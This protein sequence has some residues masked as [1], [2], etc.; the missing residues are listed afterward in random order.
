MHDRSPYWRTALRALWS[1]LRLPIV[2]MLV[3][4]EPVVSIV[5]NGIAL[6]G[7]LMVIFYKLVG[8]PHFPTWTMLGVS[9]GFALVVTLYRGLIQIL[10]L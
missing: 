3:L 1:M 8:L 5:F 9:L 7:V 10:S 2:T 6:L 4:L